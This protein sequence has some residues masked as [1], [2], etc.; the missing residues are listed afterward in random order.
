MGGTPTK[1]VDTTGWF[2]SGSA[3]AGGKGCWCCADG[4]C[5]AVCRKCESSTSPYPLCSDDCVGVEMPPAEEYRRARGYV[6]TVT[7]DKYNDDPID[8]APPGEGLTRSGCVSYN[9]WRHYEIQTHGAADA[10]LVVAVDAPVGG[11]YAARGRPPTATDHDVVARPPNRFLP[12]TACDVGAPTTWHVA[13]QLGAETAGISE[14]LFN[15]TIASRSAAAEVGSVVP[16][17]ACC[18]GFSHWR[19]QDVPSGAALRANVTLSAGSLHG[20]FLQYD[21]CATYDPMGAMSE[22]CTGLCTVGWLTTWDGISG[23]RQNKSAAVVTVPTGMSLAESDKRRGGTWYVSAKALPGE[24]ATFTLALELF[25]P[26]GGAR[27]PPPPYCSG[28]DRYCAS[29]TQRDAGDLLTT[30]A[31]DRGVPLTE[32]SAA[33]ATRGTAPTRAAAVAAA[34]VVVGASRW[35]RRSVS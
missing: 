6:M 29:Q 1:G 30:S 20:L 16:G 13:V 10:G 2:D 18:G 12:L 22:Q 23:G 4:E 14:T 31:D 34:V 17:S 26:Q 33:A 8:D 21:T 35:W 24:S 27:A 15:M 5:D 19:V 32:E 28:T 25:Y 3:I 9:Q 11:I 7:L